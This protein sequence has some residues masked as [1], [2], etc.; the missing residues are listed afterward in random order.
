MLVSELSEDQQ[1][2]TRLVTDITKSYISIQTG[3]TF[4]RSSFP[5]VFVKIRLTVHPVSCS[6]DSS[7]KKVNF[8]LEQV[9][10]TQKG[11]TG[12]AVLFL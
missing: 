9:T 8:T 7:I 1:H 11:S 6:S 3:I 2:R 10:E 4:P 5:T 12:I